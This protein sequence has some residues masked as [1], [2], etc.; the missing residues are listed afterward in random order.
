[1]Q[2]VFI[3]DDVEFA[4]YAVDDIPFFVVDQFQQTGLKSSQEISKDFTK[5][6]KFSRKYETLASVWWFL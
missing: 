4:S 1:M 6:T 2:F 3:M 5:F